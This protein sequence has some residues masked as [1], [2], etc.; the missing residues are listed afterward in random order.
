MTT[1]L[2]T[3]EHARGKSR[4]NQVSEVGEILSPADVQARLCRVRGALRVLYLAG[5]EVG[6]RRMKAAALD[7]MNAVRA[8]G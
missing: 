6:S 4:D 1:T 8:L 7:G 3:I 2:V 5:E